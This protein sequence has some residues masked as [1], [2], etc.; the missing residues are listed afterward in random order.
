MS[1][2]GGTFSCGCLPLLLFN[3]TLGGW[4]IHYVLDATTGRNIPFWADILIGLFTAQISVPA[5]VLCWGLNLAG[6][7]TPFFG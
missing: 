5:M 6:I 3:V 2:T 4:S 7:D 1:H